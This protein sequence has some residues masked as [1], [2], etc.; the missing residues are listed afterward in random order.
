MFL[1]RCVWRADE[2]LDLTVPSCAK[3]WLSERVLQW[4]WLPRR[5]LPVGTGWVDAGA[6]DSW[7]T[8]I[9]ALRTIGALVGGTPSSRPTTLSA[10]RANKV[11]ERHLGHLK[12]AVWRL[13]EEVSIRFVPE[14]L[15]PVFASLLCPD[16]TDLAPV[17]EECG[18]ELPATAGGRPSRRRACVACRVRVFR[19]RRRK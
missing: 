1:W 4:Q 6:R 11:A 5:R 16:L 12:P 9:R 3:V 18:R 10:K 7:N 15:I 17:C 13:H 2:R 14:R 19:E 8:G